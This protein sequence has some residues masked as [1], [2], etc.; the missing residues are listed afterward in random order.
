MTELQAPQPGEFLLYKTEDDRTSVE[1]RFTEDTI[2]AP[3]S[4]YRHIAD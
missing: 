3:V 2:W 1:C 4:G